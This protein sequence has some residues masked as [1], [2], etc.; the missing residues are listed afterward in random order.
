MVAS[1]LH[2]HWS[3]CKWGLN[4]EAWWLDLHCLPVQRAAEEDEK[5][6]KSTEWTLEPVMAADDL[7]EQWCA[8]LRS[9]TPEAL[10]HKVKVCCSCI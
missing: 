5:S 3:Q 1:E 8:F 10:S 7:G 4:F 6:E 9:W 2:L